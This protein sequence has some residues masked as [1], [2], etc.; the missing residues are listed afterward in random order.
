[1]GRVAGFYG[2]RGWIKVER[3]EAGLAECGEWWIG[4]EPHAVQETKPHSG[5]LLAKL[6]GIE[7]REVAMK[8][9]GRAIEVRRAALPEPQAGHYYLADLIGLEVVNGKGEKLGVVKRF[10][11]NGP[12]DVME[13]AG[14]RERLLPWVPT[15]VKG[16]DLQKRRIEVEWEADW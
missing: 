12:Q 9:R 8:L 13:L 10:L 16:V 1:M 14:E 3:P 5:S 7:N 11:T 4:G 15:V 6:A 2:V